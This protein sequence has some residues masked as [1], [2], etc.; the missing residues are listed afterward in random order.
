MNTQHPNS[1]PQTVSRQSPICDYCQAFQYRRLARRYKLAGV[2]ISHD[3][4][5]AEYLA[6]AAGYDHLAN[7]LA[8][9]CP[10]LQEVAG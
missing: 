6:T 8:A 4:L 9:R 3:K 1:N 10:W 2:S 7:K 5:R